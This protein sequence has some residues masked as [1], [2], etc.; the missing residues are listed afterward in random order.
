LAQL[1]PLGWNADDPAATSTP[2]AGT[3]LRQ[4]G[5]SVVIDLFFSFD[6][7]HEDVL[8][9]SEV[10]PF[11]FAGMRY[12]FPFL[13][14]DDLVVFKMSFGRPKDWVDIEAMISAGTPVDADYVERQLVAFKGPLA[15]PAMARLRM[16]LRN[17]AT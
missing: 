10:K 14:A 17:R 12:T 16:M 3:R 8:N 4:S 5:E 15:H 13:S 11:L 2:V 9:R 6:D 7:Y 1:R